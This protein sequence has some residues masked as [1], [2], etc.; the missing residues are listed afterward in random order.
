MHMSCSDPPSLGATLAQ[1]RRL[2]ADAASL[3]TTPERPLTRGLPHSARSGNLRAVLSRLTRLV[4]F[5]AAV[6]I[7]G[8]HWLA[9]QSVAWFGMIASYSRSHSLGVA[10]EKTFD[11]ANPCGLCTVV[12]SGREQEQKQ[13]VSKVVWKLDAV[14]APALA[15]PQPDGSRW[16]YFEQDS[17]MAERA[18][19]PP[20]PPPQA[21]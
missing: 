6:Q 16:E 9:L 11:G 21:A 3:A 8:G 20:T 14:L 10:I 1:P 15:L 13:Q 7:L 18:L 4:V 19:A 12:K 5:L 2:L 17:I